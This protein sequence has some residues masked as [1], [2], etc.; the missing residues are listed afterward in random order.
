MSTETHNHAAGAHQDEMVHAHDHTK[1]FI[2]TICALFVLTA[3]TV[4]AATFDF[5]SNFINLMIAMAIATMKASLVAMFFMH[6]FWEKG[7]NAIIFLSSLFFV[8]VF[9]V[10]TFIDVDSRAHLEA[11]TPDP[12]VPAGIEPAP[13]PM[14]VV[15]PTANGENGH[16]TEEAKPEAAH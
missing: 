8:G 5:G 15:Q 9:M 7:M 12:G 10:F 6:L 2:G 3:I 1:W 13:I 11:A 14:Y 16:A 4:Y